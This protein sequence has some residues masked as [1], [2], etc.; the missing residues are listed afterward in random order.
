MDEPE[1]SA[2]RAISLLKMFKFGI[3]LET[4]IAAVTG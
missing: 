3:D 2:S 1:A 4:D